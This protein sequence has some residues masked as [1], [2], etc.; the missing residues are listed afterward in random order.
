MDCNNCNYKKSHLINTVRE[1]KPGTT[2]LFFFN[3]EEYSFEDVDIYNKILC[4]AL[5]ENAFIFMP[6]S[7]VCG[8]KEEV[9]N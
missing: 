3:D 7:L 9:C 6:A 8:V 5:P 1:I 2:L 4:D